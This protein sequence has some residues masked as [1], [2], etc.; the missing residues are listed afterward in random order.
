MCL[1]RT[2]IFCFGYKIYFV[3]FPGNL[4]SL[5]LSRTALELVQCLCKVET[6]RQGVVFKLALGC[7]QQ[8]HIKGGAQRLVARMR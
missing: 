7:R 8:S 6:F 5:L 3:A 4:P 2:R 1:H